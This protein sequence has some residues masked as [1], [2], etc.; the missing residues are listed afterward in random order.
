MLKALYSLA[1]RLL[2]RVCEMYPLLCTFGCME[3]VPLSLTIDDVAEANKP[4]FRSLT[5]L[6]CNISR[7]ADAKHLRVH[8]R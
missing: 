7:N 6:G 2:G 4:L 8:E 1:L 5:Q 3:G